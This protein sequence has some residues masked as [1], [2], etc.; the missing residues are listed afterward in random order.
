MSLDALTLWTVVLDGLG[1]CLCIVALV[2]ARRIGTGAAPPARGFQQD[3]ERE[4]VRQRI[5]AAFAAIAEG[6]DA[7]RR[8]LE[9]LW[10]PG[11]SPAAAPVAAA[12]PR[13]IRPSGAAAS[14]SGPGDVET[15]IEGMA[16]RGM[17]VE[18][19]AAALQRP[20]AEV[21]LSLKLRRRKAVS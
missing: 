19:I 5:A 12:R 1:L 21:A 20:Q 6:V 9:D 8:A 14:P 11:A 3:V 2:A 7:E 13:A 17:G 15:A 4:A 10:T 16:A 18:A